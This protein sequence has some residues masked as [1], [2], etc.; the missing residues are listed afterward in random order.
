[1]ASKRGESSV[2]ECEERPAEKRT[3][4]VIDPIGKAHYS[5]YRRRNNGRAR[6]DQDCGFLGGRRLEGAILALAV[7]EYRARQKAGTTRPR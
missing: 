2:E 4:H 6:S 1:M 3:H 7:V 5:E